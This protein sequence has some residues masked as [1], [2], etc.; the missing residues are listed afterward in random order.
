MLANQKSVILGAASLALGFARARWL[1]AGLIVGGVLFA[2][3]GLAIAPE[4]FVSDHLQEHGI[5]RFIHA[6]HAASPGAVAYPSRT[7]LWL[8]FARHY[9]WV[10]CA[11][12]AVGIGAGLARVVR[13][14]SRGGTAPAGAEPDA[15]LTIAVVWVA[16]GAAAFTAT[17]WRQTKHL[18]KLV[19][20]MT[21]A[22]GAAIAGAPPWARLGLRAGLVA[23]LAWNAVWIVRLARDFSSMSPTP[24]W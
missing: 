2:G 10:W 3:W 24:L 12:A 18:A 15:L 20:A 9:G 6:S 16:V 22:I 8:E 23:S 4:E 11:C 14:G 17:D 5:S 19:P 1:L 7:G 13:R 21:L